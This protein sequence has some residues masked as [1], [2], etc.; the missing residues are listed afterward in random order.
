MQFTV[1]RVKLFG[2]LIYGTGSQE[3]PKA[4]FSRWILDFIT[5]K[6]IY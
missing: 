3:I 1:G 2:S 5:E 4:K 6:I